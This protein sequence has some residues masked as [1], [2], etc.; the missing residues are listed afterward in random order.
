MIL[1]ITGT[2]K[3]IG[4]HLAEYYLSLGHTV[5]GCSRHE[6]SITH[7]LYT[8]CIA[9]VQSDS[10]VSDF[11]GII[12]KKLGHA[13]AL[14][15]NTGTAS[16]NHFMM[17]PM[18]T[19]VNIMDVNYFG[20]LRCIREFVGLLRKSEHP[21]IVNFSSVAVP[22]SLEGELAYS[23]SK[24]AVENMTRVLAR[25][26]AD[27]GITVNAVGPNP[28][29]TDLIRNVSERKIQSLLNRQAVHRAGR[30]EDVINVIDFYLRPESDMIT[31]QVIYLGGI[32]R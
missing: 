28:I 20:S 2:H 9:D 5:A 13:D 19:A 29:A 25:E 15:N 22:L 14:I 31:G 3:G 11:A 7:E 8:H 27:F 12:R 24:V 18:N 10:Q 16:M 23:S 4:K 32:T 17:T 21:R 26:L 30:F 6:S 1:A